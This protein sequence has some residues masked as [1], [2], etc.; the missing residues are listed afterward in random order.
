[1]KPG[2]RFFVAGLV[3]ATLVTGSVAAAAPPSR[4]GSSLG[5][6]KDLFLRGLA[7]LD[8]GDYERALD[9]FLQSKELYPSSKNTANAAICLDKLGRYDE[10]LEMYE[11]LV[12]EY[13]S[14]LDDD[15]RAAIG[16]AMATLR[17]KVGG[18]Q[19]ATNVDATAVIDG[20]PRGALPTRNP[21]RLAPGTHL[22]RLAKDGYEPIEVRFDVE[23]GVVTRLDVTLSPLRGVGILRVEDPLLKDARV[24][25]DDVEVGVTP[26]ESTLPPGRH[27]LRTE[28]GERGSAPAVVTILEG[29]T[30]LARVTSAPLG[31]ELDIQAE[32]P[33]A[34]L[35]LDGVEIGV[36]RWSGRLPTGTHELVVADRGYRTERRAVTVQAGSTDARI[37]VSLTIDPTQPRWAR[38]AVGSFYVGARGSAAVSASLRSDA[39]AQCASQCASHGP[40]W[41]GTAELRVGFRF[42]AGFEIEAS[43]GYISLRRDLVRSITV[44]RADLAPVD[45]RLEDAL[46]L[47]GGFGALGV[48]YR[49]RLTGPLGFALRTRAGLVSTSSRDPIAGTASVNGESL[50]LRV[51]NKSTSVSGVLPF[52]EPFAGLELSSGGFSGGLGLGVGFFP[53]ETGAF[54]HDEIGVA[55]SCPTTADANGV[56]CIANSDLL[57]RERASGPFVAWL[58]TLDAAYAF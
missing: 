43:G 45:Y 6:A 5:D 28:R 2:L 15:D 44:P 24:F 19:I 16:P 30:T 39:E 32:P 7:L 46:S 23:V 47:R 33:T 42:N 37:R 36:R 50:P 35:V 25:V 56:G 51:A 9:Y 54:P 21:F 58:P 52:V 48:G 29:Q 13:Q 12:T 57:A 11:Q 22:L 38:P 31:P 4:E 8:A 17:A 10:A 20:R 27:I 40:A 34:T 53:L 18:V 55:P 26:W 41:G 14:E 1:M 3:A 49:R